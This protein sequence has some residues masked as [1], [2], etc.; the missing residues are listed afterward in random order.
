MKRLIPL[1][2]LLLALVSIGARAEETFWVDVD[3][4]D[5]VWIDDD[6]SCRWHATPRCALTAPNV[7][8]NH[9]GA[10]EEYHACQACVPDD[11]EYPGV[12]SWSRGGTAIVRVPDRWIEDALA[13][14][15]AAG[16]VPDAL[17]HQGGTDDEDLARLVHGRAYTA[18]VDALEPGTARTARAVMPEYAGDDLLMSC[19]HLGAAWYLAVRPAGGVRE[20]F[21]LPLRLWRVGLSVHAYEAG[22]ILS[23]ETAACKMTELSLTPTPSSGEVAWQID[24]GMMGEGQTVIRDGDVYTLVLRIHD[25]NPDDPDAPGLSRHARFLRERFDLNGY[26]DGGD[27]VFVVALTE[28]EAA[29]LKQKLDFDTYVAPVWRTDNGQP[30]TEAQL[31][32]DYAP[33]SRATQPDGTVVELTSDTYPVGTPFI[34]WTL[35]RPEGG[36]ARFWHQSPLQWLHDGMWYPVGDVNL[37]GRVDGDEDQVRPGWF[38]D[39]VNQ[40]WPVE[41]FGALREGLYRVLADSTWLDDEDRYEDTWVEFRV[42]DGAPQ[43]ELPAPAIHR[44]PDFEIAAHAV[45]HADTAVYNSCTDNTRARLSGVGWRLLAGDVVYELRGIDD[46]WGWA[47]LTHNSL[48]AYPAGQPERAA[49]LL[50]DIDHSDMALYDLGDGLL[51]VDNGGACYRCD[52]DGGNQRHIGTPFEEE[53]ARLYYGG[54]AAPGNDEDYD[55]LSVLPVGDGLYLATRGGVWYSGLDVIAPKRVYRAEEEMRNFEGGPMVYADGRLFVNDGGL[56]ALDALRPDAEGLLPAKRLTDSDEG[57]DSTSGYDYIALNGRLY[58][59]S[60][61]KKATVSVGF[62]GGDLQTVSREHFWFSGVSPSGTVL[63]LTGSEEGMFG[64]ERTAAAFYFP[65]DPENPT[66]DPDHCE[67][68]EIAPNDYDYFLGDW[69]VHTDASGAET[70]ERLQGRSR[71]QL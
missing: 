14:G 5:T 19:R 50:D 15:A 18:L 25:Y 13:M 42:V 52:L 59:W 46:S 10:T 22:V 62:D 29:A 54:E 16:E 56:V 12:E 3:T 31:A 63:A 51:L 38:C 58:F 23:A 9:G 60:A 53:H 64:D 48:F 34:A 55:V 68:R 57:W 33:V 17:I 45:A 11:G 66:F 32:P 47:I 61:A 41:G 7:L 8:D 71:Q 37:W 36:V 35:S 1:I 26:A 6:T 70:W 30:V 28:G 44:A 40:V 67:K 4:S 21:A 39:R 27:G 65:P 24:D 43:P 49:L 2:I 69:V 20:N